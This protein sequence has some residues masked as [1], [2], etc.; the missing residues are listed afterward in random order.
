MTTFPL[1]PASTVFMLPLPLAKTAGLAVLLEMAMSPPLTVFAPFRAAP[2]PAQPPLI[3][4]LPSAPASTTL[5]LLSPVAKTAAWEL[6]LPVLVIV[7]SPPVATFFPSKEALS[8]YQPP[9]MLTLPAAPASIVFA[10]SRPL[11]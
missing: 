1:V 11:A 3:T 9:L 7:M 8:P 10:L 6:V 2:R 5:E 4:I